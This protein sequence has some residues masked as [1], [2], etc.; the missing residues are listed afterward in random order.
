MRLLA[1][2]G[3]ILLLLL[4][5]TGCAVEPPRP[6]LL[7]PDD[8]SGIVALVPP[9]VISGFGAR[10]GEGGSASLTRHAGIDIRAATGTPVLAAADGLVVR[11]GSQIFAGRLILIEHDV[12]LTTAYYHLSVVEVVV[13][14]AV[15][16][17]E[18]IGR[19]GMTGNATAPHLHFGVC[20][21]EGGLCGDRIDTGWEDP[22]RNWIAAN[23]CFVAGFAYTP[24]SRR[25]TY[26]VPCPPAPSVDLPVVHAPGAP[27]AGRTSHRPA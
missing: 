22:A 4:S 10:R 16:R 12:D 11:T 21:R 15:R 24:Q 13:G 25:L 19:V 6:V 17:G 8:G 27:L 2:G 23:P 20:R 18:V 14:Q 9:P 7:P 1:R 5:V 3:R 26:P